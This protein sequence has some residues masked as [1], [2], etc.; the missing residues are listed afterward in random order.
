MAII[1]ASYFCG[2]RQQ[3]IEVE[4]GIVFIEL[5]QG[6]GKLSAAGCAVGSL[7]RRFAIEVL[8]VC[9]RIGAGIVDNAVPIIRRLIER[10]MRMLNCSSTPFKPTCQ[11]L[12]PI[13]ETFSPVLPSVRVS[14][15]CI[16]VVFD[17]VSLL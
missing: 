6:T 4:Q 10:M 17:M 8:V 3:T 13:A 11:P 7:F 15:P 9:L 12:I 1:F 16:G 14:N 2:F 5:A